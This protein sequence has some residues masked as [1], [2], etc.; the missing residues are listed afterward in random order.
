MSLAAN[1]ESADGSA[2]GSIPVR[3]TSL[4]SGVLLNEFLKHASG[5]VRYHAIPMRV[6]QLFDELGCVIPRNRN[7]QNAW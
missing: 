7:M 1:I 3:V 2:T 5:A 4:A 6:G